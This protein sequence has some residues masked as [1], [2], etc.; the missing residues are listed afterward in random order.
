M[1]NA[2]LYTILGTNIALFFSGIGLSIGLF[3]WAIKQARTDYLHLDRKLEENRKE[4]Q[5]LCK[6][7][8][9][10]VIA[11]KDDM[12]DFH[13]RLCDIEKGRIKK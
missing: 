1:E 10:T 5:S 4:T 11:I 13:N 12:K 7:I 3:L 6:E 9:E 2:Q 8:H